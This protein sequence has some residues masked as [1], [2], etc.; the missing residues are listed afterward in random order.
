MRVLST[1]GTVALWVVNILAAAAFVAIGFGKFAGPEWPRKF[2]RWGYPDGFYIVIGAL[3][4]AGG[5]MLL[6]PKLS[7]YAAAVLGVILL[8]AAATLR[9]NHLPMSAPVAWLAVLMLIGVAPPPRLASRHEPRLTWSA[10]RWPLSSSGSTLRGS[11]AS[12]AR[13]S[14]TSTR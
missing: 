1:V 10:T 9:L 8:A 13:R 12:I 7:S 2:E 3:E 4:I 5:V 14:S 11:S 6:V